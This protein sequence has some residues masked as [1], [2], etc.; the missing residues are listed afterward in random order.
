M[1]VWQEIAQHTE[2]Y[3]QM[4]SNPTTGQLVAHRQVLD[5]PKPH[6]RTWLILY[7]AYARSLQNNS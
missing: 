2:S 5:N 7:L 3:G 6:L 4:A 1:R